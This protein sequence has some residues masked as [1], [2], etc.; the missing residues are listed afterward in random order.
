MN[1]Y[2][3][4][5]YQI[6]QTGKSHLRPSK[7]FVCKSNPHATDE[8]ESDYYLHRDGQWRHQALNGD[9]PTGYFDTA[10]EAA[11]C[12]AMALAMEQEW[13]TMPER[14]EQ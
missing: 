4:S 8:Y 3:T 7:W 13:V 1:E 2:M 11:A 10:A 6:I 5:G 9:K 12:L 14:N